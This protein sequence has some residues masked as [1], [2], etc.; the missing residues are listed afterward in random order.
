MLK[1]DVELLLLGGMRNFRWLEPA[2]FIGIGKLVEALQTEQLKEQR[3]GLVKQRASRLLGTTGNAN[4]FSL[5][6]RGQHTID[7]HSA[8]RLNFRAANRLAISDDRQRLQAGLAQAR[9]L[10]RIKETIGPDRVLR[11]GFKL[12]TARHSLNHEAGSILSQFF[13]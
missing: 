8:H 11:T 13:V 1:D 6:Q 3:R 10:G 5:Q 7:R 12:V 9:G 2:Q 4:D